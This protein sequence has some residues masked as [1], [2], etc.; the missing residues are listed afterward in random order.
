[1]LLGQRLNRALAAGSGSTFVAIDLHKLAQHWLDDI[2]VGGRLR[3]FARCRRCRGNEL[4]QLRL[5]LANLYE[6]VFCSRRGASS[7]EANYV[8]SPTDNVTGQRF[9]AGLAFTV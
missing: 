8:G 2:G 5:N 7:D 9:D 6:I 4:D 1:M 3:R